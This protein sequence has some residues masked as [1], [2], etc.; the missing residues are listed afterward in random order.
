MTARL[1]RPV[2]VA[3][4][5]LLGALLIWAVILPVAPVSMATETA[6]YND[7]RLYADIVAAVAGGKNYYLAV[8]DLHR[9]HG[10][11]LQ[12]FFAVRLPSLAWAA[13]LLGWPVL[14][15][16]AFLLLMAGGLTWFSALQP[17]HGWGELLSGLLFAVV[18]GGAMESA[19]GMLFMHESWVGLLL[20]PA[21]PIL[22]AWPDRWPIAWILA[23]L[24]LVLREL[25]LPFV[26]LAGAHALV[27]R[28]WQQLAAWTGLVATFAVIVALHRAQ[29]LTVARADDMASAGWH[30]LGGPSQFVGAA[31]QSSSLQLL[32]PAIARMA[33][34]LPLFGFLALRGPRALLV[35]LW[36]AGMALAI[37]LFA[38]PDNVYWGFV[39]MPAYMIGLALVP[40]LIWDIG[41]GLAGKRGNGPLIAREIRAD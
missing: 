34:L 35:W 2:A 18:L 30:S 13:A 26:L 5:L 10:Y 8:A 39:L 19:N 9:A 17:E 20:F 14:R 36:F 31:I 25:A 28:D 37:A 24:A 11:P 27:R 32:P 6:P 29:V 21:L 12:P 22:W 1:T 15:A 4:V 38:R 33:A 23:A 40:R 16:I 7:A 41:Q 3:L